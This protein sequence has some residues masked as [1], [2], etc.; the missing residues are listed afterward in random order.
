MAQVYPPGWTKAGER[1]V[2]R[3]TV[4]AASNAS[5]EREICSQ[6]G[7]FFLVTEK[8]SFRNMNRLKFI[9]CSLV[10]FCSRDRNG[11][12]LRGPCCVSG[13]AD[14]FIQCLAFHAM[15]TVTEQ[16]SLLCWLS[17]G[18]LSIHSG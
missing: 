11:D 14:T 4:L 5:N 6:I 9:F 2:P 7:L 18:L 17:T 12:I 10:F 3:R 8:K 16:H 15:N 1:L 13:T